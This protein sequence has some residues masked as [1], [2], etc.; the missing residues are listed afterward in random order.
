MNIK[1]KTICVCGSIKFAREMKEVAKKLESEGKAVIIPLSARELDEKVARNESYDR[2]KRKRDIDA[3]NVHFQEIERSDAILV[4]NHDKNGIKN[5]IGANTFLEMGFAHFLKKKIYLL[6][7]L[8]DMPYL[9]DELAAFDT[10][11]VK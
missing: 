2:A 11:V 4:L 1:E 9:N 7:P 5:Y 3:I 6:N 8:P 10:A